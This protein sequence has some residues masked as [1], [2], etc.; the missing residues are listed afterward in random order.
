LINSILDLGN[1]VEVLKKTGLQIVEHSL[2]SKVQDIVSEDEIIISTP[3]ENGKI[4]P[5]EKMGEYYLSVYTD[6]GL[7]RC[8]ALVSNRYKE[9][10][11]YYASLKLL[12]KLQKFQ[13]R[14]YYRLDCVLKFKLKYLEEDQKEETKEGT[15][16]EVWHDAVFLD[17]S[18]G[19]LRF[20]TDIQL[21]S[22]E[23]IICHLTLNYEGNEKNLFVKSKVIVCN[24]VDFKTN[25]F[26][27]RA[28]FDDISNEDREVVIRY[29]FDEE[30]KRRKKEKGM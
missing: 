9:G 19:G 5:L 18:G 8:E 30:R 1:K 29:I 28:F 17:I 20:N 22:G 12:T 2:Y 21:I 10:N 27:A 3:I 16:E 7:Y 4:V 13:R 6:K 25:S 15:K 23:T 11:M 14:Q 26:E 24:A